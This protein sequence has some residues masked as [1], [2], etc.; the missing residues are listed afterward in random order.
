MSNEQSD[1]NQIKQDEP[2]EIDTSE[3]SV[4]K[5]DTS[6]Y[7]NPGV[8]NSEPK[9]LASQVVLEP[10]FV[11]PRWVRFLEM[12]LDKVFGSGLTKVIIFL[13]KVFIVF[14]VML[15]FVLAIIAKTD[16]KSIQKMNTTLSSFLTVIE[17]SRNKPKTT[18]GYESSTKTSDANKSTESTSTNNNSSNTKSSNEKEVVLT[19]SE[20]K[21]LN[22]RLDKLEQEN[23][24]K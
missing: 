21:A 12:C 11:Q 6:G 8:D 20:F 2:Q 10:E 4:E 1:A 3:E 22:E 23:N 7:N 14:I 24:N 16:A 5:V 19:E 17:Q 18:K 15:M 13:N 9:N